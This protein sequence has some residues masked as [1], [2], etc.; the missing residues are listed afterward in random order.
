VLIQQFVKEEINNNNVNLLKQT[1][2]NIE[3]LFNEQE[4]LYLHIVASAIEFMNLKSTLE[5]PYPE[6]EDFRQLASLKNFIDSPAIGRPY[7]DSIYIYLSNSKNRFISSTTGGLVDLKDYYDRN[8]YESSKTH[9]KEEEMWTESRTIKKL[10]VKNELV[11][12]DLITLF[13]RIS[14]SDDSDG[15]IVLN[16]KPEYIRQ[17]LD[18]LATQNGQMLLIMNP[19]NEI[20]IQ[21]QASSNL[22]KMNLTEITRQ[23]ESLFEFSW[24]ERAFVINKLYSEKYHWTFISIVP[25]ASLYEVPNRLITITITLLL[26]SLLGGMMLAYALT[27]RNYSDLK[28]I[29]LML[30]SAKHGRSLPPLPKEGKSVYSYIMHSL[31]QNFIEQNYLRVQ[32]SERKYKAQAMEFAALQAQIN[33]H[34]L[35]NTL[36]TL[37]W[38]AASLTG[39][40]NE[41]NLIVE[42]LSD[43]LRYSLDSPEGLMNLKAEI[44]NTHSYIQIQK[45]RYKDKFDVIWEYEP[46]V[47]KYNVLKLIFQPLIE[48]SLYHGIKER[49]EKCGIKIRITADPSR[50]NIAVI[51]NGVGILPERLAFLQKQLKNAHWDQT[52]HIGL[53]NTQKRLLLTYGDKFGIRLRSKFGWGTVIYITIPID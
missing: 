48:N 36:D 29:I 15:M 40:P 26:L 30:D 24:N 8:W 3:L 35:Y 44:A 7:I 32:L 23:P 46:E 33:P 21:N 4:S 13:R 52:R 28:M 37:N 18:S 16:I 27:K 5:K 31:L 41:I 12:T 9:S 47:E 43:I 39:K 49:E 34:F 10:N 6:P 38:K 19:Q 22:E 25:K 42:N 50:L 17:Q 20:L 53:F 1:Q 2:E 14:V 11:D 45:I 51:D